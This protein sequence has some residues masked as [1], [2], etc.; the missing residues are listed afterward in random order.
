MI[1]SQTSGF[2]QQGKVTHEM[3]D[4][5]LNIA[6]SSLPLNSK[7]RVANPSNGK[8]IEVTITR[9]I[10]ASSS[11]IAD[12]SSSVW[13]ELGLTPD[14]DVR[15]Y[16]IVSA[17][18]Q[19]TAVQ[20]A[21]AQ[22]TTPQTAASSA[23]RTQEPAART[24]QAGTASG[25]LGDL[26]SGIKFEN[27]NN[28]IING[29]PVGGA[30][31]AVV[32]E[33]R[34]QPAQPVVTFP[35][36]SPQGRGSPLDEP[37]PQPTQPAV[38]V[39]DWPQPAQPVVTY[40]P[41]PQPSQPA[42]AFPQPSPQGRGSPVDETSPA[43]PAAAYPQPSLQGRGSPVDG[44]RPQQVQ[45][46]AVSDI[47]AQIARPAALIE[48]RTG[49][50]TLSNVAATPASQTSQP[51]VS[52]ETRTQAVPVQ[53]DKPSSFN[54]IVAQASKTLVFID[55]PQGTPKPSVTINNGT[56]SSMPPV[57]DEMRQ[58]R[59]QSAASYV[60]TP[61]HSNVKIENWPSQPDQRAVTFETQTLP[62]QPVINIINNDTRTQQ[63]QPVVNND[64]RT[65]QVQPVV[66]FETRT[67]E[68]PVDQAGKPLW[69]EIPTPGGN[70]VFS[71]VSNSRVFIDAP[72]T[73]ARPSVIIN[74]APQPSR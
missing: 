26:P 37:R 36:P 60:S 30:P 11:R 20:P 5:G 10:P 52:F 68:V 55:A 35:Q 2:S 69:D 39:D 46:A 14:T 74:N 17:R 65:Q 29:N 16:T 59:A 64:I 3:K 53:E 7:A 71:P 45:P 41:P 25:S 19:P 33:T 22:T 38:I 8:E 23:A 67:I 42:V 40:E 72:P 15:I 13:Q 73:A 28:F 58:Q 49:Q 34:T 32:S 6:H 51:V 56:L 21:V 24:A 9:L 1:T 57:P 27:N 61:S 44:P 47:W 18:P 4:E 63:V 66:T 31:S 70:E 54:E 50:Q 43:Q 62:N 48:T 12:V